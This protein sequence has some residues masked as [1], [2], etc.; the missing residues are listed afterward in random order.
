MRLF[1]G[2]CIEIMNNLISEGVKVDAVICDPPYDAIAEEWDN[3]ISFEDMW[4]CLYK[5]IKLP[6][7]PIVL[8]AA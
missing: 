6:E 3:I 1:Q 5:I 7:T 4:K 8:F 2:D